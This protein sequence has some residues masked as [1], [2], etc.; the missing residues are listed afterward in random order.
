MEKSQYNAYPAFAEHKA[1]TKNGLLLATAYEPYVSEILA[2][3]KLYETLRQEFAPLLPKEE[4]IVECVSPRATYYESYVG[5]DS[6]WVVKLSYA[7]V[8]GIMTITKSDGTDI[9][10]LG[11]SKKDFDRVLKPGPE[12]EYSVGKAY[13][14]FIKGKYK[15]NN[16]TT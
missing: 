6:S 11:V 12:S 3:L 5:I 10:H 13:N 2:A 9:V 8:G 14:L 4:K 16:G 15:T 7:A 1:I